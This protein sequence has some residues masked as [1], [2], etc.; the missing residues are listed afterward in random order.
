MPAKQKS[1]NSIFKTVRAQMIHITCE[2]VSLWFLCVSVMAIHALPSIDTLYGL[3]HKHLT[4]ESENSSLKINNP[5]SRNNNNNN[6]KDD[7]CFRTIG[8]GQSKIYVKVKNGELWIKW[9]IETRDHY[10][11]RF[12]SQ[13]MF[14]W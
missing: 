11:E 14:D 7:V 3:A 9:L 1:I 12:V 13:G 4:I 10:L 5:K 6:T 8:F 2:L